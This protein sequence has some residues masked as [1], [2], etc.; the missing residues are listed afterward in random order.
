MKIGIDI[1]GSHIGIGVVD[2]FGKLIE[3]KEIRILK[4]NK[5]NIKNFIEDFLVENIKKFILKYQIDFIGIAS[6]G[7][8]KDGIILESVN[9]KFKNYNIVQNLTNKIGT[10]SLN[11]ISCAVK[12][13]AQCAALAEKKYGSLKEDADAIFLTIGTG[14]GG[15]V[16]YNNQLAKSDDISYFEFGHMILKPNGKKC[17][18]GKKGCFEKYAS[19]KTLKN[20]LREQL[21]L[22]SNTSGKELLDI[23]NKNS[24]NVI[25]KNIIN[26]YIN[27]LSIGISKLIEKFKIENISIGG[28]FV[29]FKD[30]FLNKLEKELFNK[31]G[32][33]VNIKIATLGNDAGIIGS[34][35]IR[36]KSV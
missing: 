26:Q 2:R 18:C 33:K 31:I 12:N 30:I 20:T 21:E 1:G 3:K 7:T 4:E 35:L 13:D 11:N 28:S 6:A 22:D 10:K 23:I 24:D 9:L 16:F 5:N 27:Y 36:D 19:M 15:A 34:T 17:N 8:I 32:K 14:I 25:I 29:Y